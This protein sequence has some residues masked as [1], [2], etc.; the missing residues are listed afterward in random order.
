[1]TSPSAR[2]VTMDT[3]TTTTVQVVPAAA[4]VTAPRIPAELLLA[5]FAQLPLRDVAAAARVCRSWAPTGVAVL[6]R[7]PPEHVLLQLSAGD[8]DARAAVHVTE[9]NLVSVGAGRLL[10][11]PLPRVTSLRVSATVV[12]R[13]TRL[14]CTFVQERSGVDIALAH[15]GEGGGGGGAAA[16]ATANNSR[17]RR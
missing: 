6:W 12:Q 4:A 14:F 1:M 15:T 7:S 3:T 17:K 8:L 2:T 11:A 9:L 13:H 5:V 16:A 10:A